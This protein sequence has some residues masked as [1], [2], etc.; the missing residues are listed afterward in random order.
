MAVKARVGATHRGLRKPV[1]GGRLWRRLVALL[2]LV[3]RLRSWTVPASSPLA[4]GARYCFCLLRG[5]RRSRQFEGGRRGC[6]S[7]I[8]VPHRAGSSAL[9]SVVDGAEERGSRRSR[10]RRT[11]S[12]QARAKELRRSLLAPVTIERQARAGRGS[13]P[14]APADTAAARKLRAVDRSV[15]EGGEARLMKSA[16][17]ARGVAAER[18]APTAAFTRGPRPARALGPWPGICHHRPRRRISVSKRCPPA[19][20]SRARWPSSARPLSAEIDSGA[21]CRFRLRNDAQD[22]A[23]AVSLADARGLAGG[24]GPARRRAPTSQAAAAHAANP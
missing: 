22:A 17:S 20:R 23:D 9:E 21:R 16:R 8:G 11:S 18:E 7:R 1:V 3:E 4:P 5:G 13:R 24:A 10:L 2:R 19:T 6:R 12:K 14:R 15:E